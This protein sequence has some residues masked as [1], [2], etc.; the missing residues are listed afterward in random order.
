MRTDEF[1]EG[2]SMKVIDEVEV[3]ETGGETSLTVPDARTVKGVRAG[4]MVRAHG[5]DYHV[6][7]RRGATIYAKPVNEDKDDKDKSDTKKTGKDNQDRTQKPVDGKDTNPPSRTDDE[8]A[9]KEKENGPDDKTEPVESD[10][11]NDLVDVIEGEDQSHDSGHAPEAK[12][13]DSGHAEEVVG[14]DTTV[15]V[16]DRNDEQEKSETAPESS[17]TNGND[18]E[19][20]HESNPRVDQS[21]VIDVDPVPVSDLPSSKDI[22]VSSPTT[23]DDGKPRHMADGKVKVIAH[24]ILNGIV[25][26]F[27][28]LGRFLKWIWRGLK[29]G[30]REL[31]H[32]YHRIRYGY[33]PRDLEHAGDYELRMMIAML[34]DC[35]Y[36][37]VD[38]PRGYDDT[39]RW[40]LKRDS[41]WYGTKMSEHGLVNLRGA[42]A[43]E[44]VSEYGPASVAWAEDLAGASGVLADYADESS[45][46]HEAAVDRFDDVWSW[47]GRNIKDIRL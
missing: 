37:A 46:R 45:P 2:V 27:K 28:A 40:L 35:A 22:V 21:G 18:E 5:V 10:D 19:L 8:K 44:T 47:I 41:D 30:C 15:G 34:E 32:W 42:N 9:D 13:D 26:V 31:G 17:E 33:S 4:S 1:K 20:R 43:D 14:P 12:S 25:I 3:G 36:N 6:L 24:A 11:D 23:T 38:P 7:R 16:E 39:E 29:A